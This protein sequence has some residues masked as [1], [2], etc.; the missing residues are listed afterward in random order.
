MAAIM[1][2][3]SK[4]YPQQTD[5]TVYTSPQ[6]IKKVELPSD[7]RE[8]SPDWWFTRLR[9]GTLNLKDTSIIYPKFL[10][11]C[12]K[13]YNWADVTFNGTDTLYVKGTG[14]RWKATLKSDNW[15]DSY[16]MVFNHNTPVWMFSDPYCN[17]GFWL[18]YMAVSIGYSLDM[19][20]IIGN[21]PANHSKWDFNF[22]CARFWFDL[23]YNENSGGTYL[24]RF[25]N[26]NNGHIIHHEFPGLTFHNFGVDGYYFFNSW[27][28]S[29][30]AAYS[31]SKIQRKS[32]GSLILGFDISRHDIKINFATLP[33]DMLEYIE[34]EELKYRFLFND[35]SLLIGYGYN[36]VFAK[37]FLFNITALP[38]VGFKHSYGA[39]SSG[40]KDTWSLGIKG[41]F[42][43][44]YNLHDFF[45]GAQ[46]KMEGHWF[47]GSDF[48]F[49]NS[50][51]NW[52]IIAGVRF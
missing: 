51:E 10:R 45:A 50:V 20:N 24:R 52:A 1:F 8:K 26:Y 12:V 46:G 32:A 2:N 41:R 36:W 19:S 4:A 43:F 11:F 37:N 5:T 13:T 49:F 21:R 35:Y 42:S 7:E 29:Q 14:R 47:R 9:N 16:A 39:S 23:Y 28:Y 3:A 6:E 38:A 22:S 27:K 17:A 44:T 25:A 48:N 30:G 40:S 33:Q 31:F 34:G 18:N 15:L